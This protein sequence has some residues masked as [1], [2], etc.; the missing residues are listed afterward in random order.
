MKT[1]ITPKKRFNF[2]AP[3]GF[4]LIAT[5]AVT[6]LLMLLAIAMLSLSSVTTKTITTENAVQGARENARLSLMMAIGQLQSLSG[7]DTRITASSRM[8]DETGVEV[9]GVW[10]S[11][12]GINRDNDGRPGIPDYDLKRETGDPSAEPEDATNDGRFLGW[13]GS[14]SAVASVD[15][16]SDYSAVATDNFIQMIGD[17]SVVD[18]E[19]HVYVRP[20]LVDTVE[21]S[22]AVAWWVSGNSSKAMVNADRKSDPTTE[23][24]W[25]ERARSNGRAD[26]EFFGLSGVDDLTVGTNVPSRNS[27]QLVDGAGDI[28]R[29]H[30]LT[31]Y[32]RGL[33]INVAAGG[34]KKDLSL[35]TEHY[36]FLPTR[37][38]P[39]LSVKPGEDLTFTRTTV[40][41][42]RGNQPTDALLYPW[43]RFRTISAAAW[44]Q[45]PPIGT[46]TSLVD[47]ALQ[48]RELGNSSQ[49]RTVIPS[50]IAGTR[51]N[52]R[53]EFQDR[54]RR[55]PIL[56]RIQWVFSFCSEEL[57]ATSGQNNNTNEPRFRPGVMLTPVVT[58]WNPY[59]VELTYSQYEIN[60]KE[61][62][63]VPLEFSFK[64]GFRST[65]P[66]TNL[67]EIVRGANS[68]QDSDITLILPVTTFEPGAS[69]V[70]SIPNLEALNGN[71]TGPITLSPG[72]TPG[73]GIR[74]YGINQGN[75]V[76]ARGNESLSIAE[77]SYSDSRQG[78]IGIRFDNEVNGEE[79]AVRMAYRE[80]ELSDGNTSGAQVIEELYPK[81]AEGV[82]VPLISEVARDGVQTVPFASAT[83]GH[84]MATPI[85]TEPQHESLYTKGMLQANPL[86]YYAEVGNQDDDVTRDSMADSGVFHP[87]NAPYDFAFLD[88]NDWFDTQFLPQ[89]DGENSYIVSGLESGDGLTRCIIAELPTRPLQSL[90]Q[91][92]HFDARNN[93]PV[94]P[95]QFNILG[96]GSAHPIF[97]PD[98]LTVPTTVNTDMVND[99]AY[100]LNNLFFD[101]WFVSSIAPDLEDFSAS[102]DRDIE[103]VYADHVNGVEPLPNRFYIPT[104]TADE[105]SV[106]ED[107]DIM[108]KDT[109]AFT[110]EVIASE[111]EVDGAFNVNSVSV[112]AWKAL[113]RHSRSNRVPYL[114][115]TGETD[116]SEE[117]TFPYSRTSIAGDRSV[118]SGSQDSNPN[119][120]S[121][122]SPAAYAGAPDLTEVQIDALAEQIVIEIRR[123]GPFLS[124]GEFVN[125]Q[126][127]TDTDLAIASTIQKAL[128]NLAE[129]S[130]SAENPF[131]TLQ[132]QAFE[133]TEAPIG[134]HEYGFPEAALG[135]SAFGVPGWIRQ[136]DI[137]T[138]L[139]PIMTVRDDTFTIRAYGDFRDV[140]DDTKILASAWCEATVQRKAD[141]IDSADEN[142]VAPYSDEMT[143][144][145][146]RRYG[147]KY[148]IIS[149][150]WL[151]KDEI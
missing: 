123:R 106:E 88:V 87:V 70:F 96:N 92:Q 64:V 89:A 41:G 45:I 146:N 113:L 6:A 48:Y 75:E 97:E 143:S 3:T 24:E 39:S 32:S 12:E 151:N 53:F 62:G 120:D 86:T 119:A 115:P 19:D 134:P 133:I 17:G 42:T 23:I 114:T 15:D 60:I 142:T 112:D 82:R 22:G 81:V 85:S 57:P 67:R 55:V 74:Y 21:N 77:V 54:V 38:L 47:Y 29:F 9:T 46:W 108:Y 95:F 126:L 34:W 59:N 107:D 11:W 58:L 104:S 124:L 94:P 63:I 78:E 131:A 52:E 51:A 141:Y 83:F 99:D 111:L 144:D 72:Y 135:S 36:E 109:D 14:G 150:R 127:T 93:N 91:L 5:I 130:N 139:A 138:P 40:A 105:D 122:F 61:Q 37:D 110:Y 31:N 26:A 8:F 73:G 69:K 117:N 16:L 13:L 90:A 116:I 147:R 44:G 28:R 80:S 132:S 50:R 98:Q 101:D 1:Y 66:S 65:F 33:L 149:F 71:S 43:G 145:V 56:A 148:E 84:R 103:E 140:N 137:L 118:L 7:P 49:G 76:S 121:G 35:L 20:K 4:A 68:N 136:A 25:Q 10:R 27:L 2:P 79:Q 125:R 18:M 102:S 30:D 128:D 129:S 100:Y